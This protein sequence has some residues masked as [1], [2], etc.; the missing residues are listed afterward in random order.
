MCVCVL[1]PVNKSYDDVLDIDV[2]VE[3]STRSE[4]WVQGLEVELVW[5][6]LWR[7]WKA[8]GQREHTHTHTHRSLFSF[9]C[10]KHKSILYACVWTG[11]SPAWGSSEPECPEQSESS[12]WRGNKNIGVKRGSWYAWRC[13]LMFSTCIIHSMRYSCARESLQFTTCSRTPARTIWGG[14]HT[15]GFSQRHMPELL[16]TLF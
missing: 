5:E 11:K 1:W 13:V 8:V 10:L 6:N 9:N 3:L 14:E 7:K 4:K 16:P 15:Q 12:R 2:L